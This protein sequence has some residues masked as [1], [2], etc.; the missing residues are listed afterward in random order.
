MNKLLKNYQGDMSVINKF[1]HIGVLT[2]VTEDGQPRTGVSDAGT[3]WINGLNFIKDG[4]E[5][6][7]ASFI[8]IAMLKNPE[9]GNQIVKAGDLVF[10]HARPYKIDR[11]EKKIL[12]GS[13]G[14]IEFMST[15]CEDPKNIKPE[16]ITLL[17]KEAA[18]A[19]TD[20]SDQMLHSRIVTKYVDTFKNSRRDSKAW[21][22]A[23][24]FLENY[25]NEENRVEISINA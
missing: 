16:Y 1:V 25:F 3:P 11:E 18:K 13:P 17:Y 19:R 10:G 6:K 24:D 9:R 7:K 15:Q 23:A 2:T 4:T 20:L 8:D 12:K 21:S 5:G 14:F 22:E